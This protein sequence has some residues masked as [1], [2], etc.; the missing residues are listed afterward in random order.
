MSSLTISILHLWSYVH[1]LPTYKTTLISIYLSVDRLWRSRWNVR[2]NL[3]GKPKFSEKTW[4]SATFVHHKIPHDQTRVWTRAAAV[5]SWRLTAW[6]MAQPAV[7][8]TYSHTQP[9]GLLGRG[10]GPSLGRYLHTQNNTHNKR[11]R[12]FIHWVEFEPTIPAFEQAKTVHALDH[13]ATVIAWWSIPE[14]IHILTV[15]SRCVVSI[16]QL[17]LYPSAQRWQSAICFGLRPSS[18][19][20]T[21]CWLHC[22]PCTWPVSTTW[23]FCVIDSIYWGVMLPCTSLIKC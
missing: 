9:V 21:H 16:F 8:V 2:V 15:T 1:Y 7:S 20:Y 14:G 12:T 4:P 22:S 17:Y 10:N 18:G 23:I 5:G 19:M 3:Q 6:A 11:T 13:A